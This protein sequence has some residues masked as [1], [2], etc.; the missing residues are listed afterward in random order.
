MRA[1]GIDLGDRRIGVA[2]TDPSGTLSSPFTVLTRS[3]TVHREIADIVDEWEIEVVV[4]G[5]PLSL[6]GSTGPAARKA[7][8]EI[9]T[10][11]ATL[12]VPVETYDERLTTVTAHQYLA[13]TGKSEKERR[14]IVDMVA[15][16][17]ILE[18]WMEQHRHEVARS[19]AALSEPETSPEPETSHDS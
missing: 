18:G 12:S 10:L 19:A 6:D 3:G 8:R 5:L 16:A 1:L 9:E 17:I 4:V 15:A 2:K 7:N 13:E 14:S 11:R